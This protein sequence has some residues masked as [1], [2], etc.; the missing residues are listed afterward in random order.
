MQEDP[1]LYI[2][3]ILEAIAYIEAD[4]AGLDFERFRRDR[5]TRQLVERNLEILSEASYQQIN[6][7]PCNAQLSGGPYSRQYPINPR[8]ETSP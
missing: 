4:T 1:G 7:S 5:R 3:H 8:R 2:R 6:R